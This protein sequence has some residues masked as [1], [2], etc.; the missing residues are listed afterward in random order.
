MPTAGLNDWLQKFLFIRT[1]NTIPDGRPLYAYK[2]S[3]KEYEQL[4]AMIH[5]TDLGRWAP[6]PP[7]AFSLFAAETWR[8][9]HIGGSWAWETVFNEINHPVPEHAW[10]RR[11]IKSDLIWWSRPLLR[12][13]FGHREFLVTIACEGG[14]PLLLLQKENAHLYRYFRQLLVTYHQERRSPPCDAT[15][16]ARRLS[17]LLPRSLRHDIVFSL[18]GELIQKVVSLQE[19]VADAHDPIS[20]LNQ[21]DVDWRN[22]L[23]LPLEDDT[24]EHFLR[25]LVNEARTLSITERQK[26]RW[27]RFLVKKDDEWTVEQLLEL[28]QNISGASLYEWLNKKEIP[29]RLR[30]FLYTAK[31]PEQIALLTRLKGD[32]DKAVYRCEVLR[33]NG[34]RLSIEEVLCGARLRLSDGIS[35]HCLPVQG[36]QEWGPLP[37]FFKTGE[38]QFEFLG[39]GSVRSRESKLYVLSPRG[40][41]YEADGDC[42]PVGLSR[43]TDRILYEVAGK[44]QWSHPELGTCRFQCASTDESTESYLLDGPRLMMVMDENSPF[45]GIPTLFSVNSDGRRRRIEDARLEWRSAAI[46]GLAWRDDIQECA[47]EVWI[48]HRDASDSQ[49]LLRKVKVVPP[50]FRISIEKTGV[51]HSEAGTIRLVGFCSCKVRVDDISGCRFALRPIADG[52]EIDSWAEPGL[53]ITQFPCTLSWGEG[54]SLVVELPFPR[55]GAAFVRAGRPIVPGGRVAVSRLAAVHALIQAHSEAGFFLINAKIKSC[56]ELRCNLTIEES[57]H[58]DSMG[59]GQFE[60]H[61]IQEKLSSMLAL[62]GD[63]D[64]VAE[65][66][67]LDNSGQV[68]VKM[69]AGL[70]E[71]AFEPDYESN[72]LSLP[73]H[74]IDQLEPDWEKRL[75]IRMIKLWKPGAEA[76]SLERCG[77]VISWS[78]PE[79]LTPG[80]WLILGDDGDWPRFRPVLWNIDGEP[81]HSESPLT[82]AILERDPLL[83][84]NRLNEVIKQFGVDP[85][86]QDWPVFFEY[87]QLTRRY[88][89]STFDLFRLLVNEPRALVLGLLKS[90]DENFDVVWSLAYQLPFSWHLVPVV[91]WQAAASGYFRSLHEAL[92]SLEQGEEMVWQAFQAIRER[93]TTRQP[94]FR[95]VCDW[96][97]N[98]MF[99]ARQLENSELALAKQ[100]PQFISGLITDEEQKLQARHDADERYP[101]GPQVMAWQHLPD[102]EQEFRYKHL[103]RPFRPVRCAPFVA[104][105]IALSGASYEESMLFELQKLRNFDR[106]WFDSAFAFGLCL[107]LARLSDAPVGVN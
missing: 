57:V 71:L 38:G 84:Q 75:R 43:G 74:C 46:N 19:Q 70:F 92:A 94:F 49:L 91:D 31:G 61:R 64:S 21:M 55:K 18:S 81:E 85:E 34:V 79:G 25:N 106:E 77:A 102:Y 83:R 76:V 107:G 1:R 87:L 41:K 30:L 8:R 69:E 96:L 42:E 90:D 12:D 28:P 14:L 66:A 26:I 22:S 47:G 11:T 29:S 63:L 98:S 105:H 10:L 103:S 33:R 56:N 73:L 37:W 82:Q 97:S 78:I 2:C 54:S 51:N 13:Q 100:A 93:V 52:V 68:L 20:A 99:P 35:D 104:A 3:A 53:P 23:P 95:Q 89:A 48:R 44:G 17:S 101:D 7:G 24:I 9:C 67:I 86:H 27:R 15:L 36:N 72:L 58:L 50:S 39:E 80:P 45:L 5:E 6:I 16:L 40:G 32:G 62:T 4:R 60:L 59:R 88:P 65:L